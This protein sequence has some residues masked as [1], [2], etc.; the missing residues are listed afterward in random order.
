VATKN[1]LDVALGSLEQ[2]CYPSEHF[3][4]VTLSHVIEH[5]P[6]PVGTLVECARL[7]KKGGKLVIATP[8]N[9]SLGHRLFGRNWRGLEPPRHLHIFSPQSLRRTLGMAGFQNIT[10]RPQVARSVILESFNL[11]R[12]AK[13][14]AALTTQTRLG[15]L[16]TRVFNGVELCLVPWRSSMADCMTAIA[17]K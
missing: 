6:D 15:W 10:I 14:G 13:D 8:N 3:D 17:V 4:A 11:W 5:V 2:Q 1:G 9:A 12:G 16:V 7:L